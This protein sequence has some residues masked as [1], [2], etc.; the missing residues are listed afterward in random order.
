MAPDHVIQYQ[1]Q[2]YAVVKGVFAPEEVAELAAAFDRLHAQA[3]QHPK[4]YRHGNLLYRL[5][6]DAD[7]GRIVRLVQ[8]PS[9]VD[10]VLDRFRLDRRILDIVAPLAGDSL[11]QIINQMHW[12]PPGAAAAEFGYHQDIRF[13]R[14]RAAYR[15]P[16]ESYIQTG[17]AIDPHRVSNGAMTVLPG[18]HLMGELEFGTQNRIMDTALSDADL[19]QVGLD[20]SA[21]VPLELDPGDVALWHL[22]LVHGSGLNRS[23][24]DRR[25]YLNGYVTAA[26]CDRGVL[27]FE[28]GE[29][30]PLGAPVLIHYE[31]LFERPEPHYVDG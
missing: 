27:A 24:I 25:F 1:R 16:A 26:N 10:P 17:I 11:K 15:R 29:P 31:E 22:H 28:R 12:K 5:G 7:L 2:G 14:P 20:P 4:S 23:T 6:R 19:R 18:S 30:R 9:Y 8:W 21:V 13:R 3:L